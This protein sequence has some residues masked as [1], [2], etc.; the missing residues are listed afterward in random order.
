[1]KKRIYYFLIFILVIALGLA[2]RSEWVPKLIYP[3]L[4]DTLYAVMMFFFIA[5][6]A[7]SRSSSYCFSVA[8]LICFSIELSQL[9][10]AEWIQE[11]RQHQM[12]AL[13]LGSG[14]LWTDLIAYLCGSILAL[15]VDRYLLADIMKD[16]PVK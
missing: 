11:I 8:L 9:Y 12:G 6:L 5:S 2:S 15:L 13:I 10:Q 7:P 1:M 16:E 14:F 3:Y 4:G